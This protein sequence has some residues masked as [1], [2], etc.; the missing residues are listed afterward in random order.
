M[1]RTVRALFLL[2]GL[3]LTQQA[4]AQ[5]VG[6]VNGSFDVTATGTSTY[7]LP[8][9]SVPGSSGLA[10]SLSLSYNSQYIGGPLGAGWSVVGLST[11][12]RG[13]RS[14]RPHGRITGV[15]LDESDLLFL[16]GEELVPIAQAGSGATQRTEYRKRNDD[17]SRIIRTGNAFASA[18]FEVQTK[19]GLRLIFDGDG[20]S[21]IAAG[22]T[23]LLQ[24]VS[25]IED[26]S[27]NFMAFEYF[28]NGY[29]DYNLA[30]VKYTGHRGSGG[31]DRQP[32]AAITFEYEAA[33]RSTTSYVA[34]QPVTSDRRLKAVW[35]G[36]L[37]GPSA[38]SQL[39]KYTF[40]YKDTA[41][42]GRFLLT[43]IHEFGTDGS[44]ISPVRFDYT[45]ASVSWTPAPAQLPVI[46]FATQ[47]AIGLGYRA[48]N[49]TAGDASPDLLFG[50]EVDGKLESFAFTNVAGAWVA[51]DKFKPPFAFA[52]ADGGDLGV[53]AGD[54]NG[55]GRI[56]LIQRTKRA[57]G[58]RAD[59]ALLASDA[60]WQPAEGYKLPFF[61]SEA[62]KRSGSAVL[63]KLS[64]A[65]R[66]DLLYEIGDKR[67]VLVNTGTGWSAA[68]GPSL[69]APLTGSIILDVDCDGRDEFLARVTANGASAWAGW[70]LADGVWEPLGEKYLPP[71][72]AVGIEA[73]LP[74]TLN[75]DNCPDLLLAGAVRLALAGS[76]EGWSQITGMTPDFSILDANGNSLE[77][78]TGDFD[79]NGLTD[80]LIHRRNEAGAVVSSAHLA[81][82]GGGWRADR[83]FVPTL[84]ADLKQRYRAPPIVADVNGDARSDILL[85]GDTRDSFG[86]VLLGGSD[87]LVAAPNYAP[88][89]VF[90]RSDMQDRGIRFVDLNADGLLD[91]IY[92]RDATREGKLEVA[93]GALLN[94]GT[95]WQSEPGLEPPLPF[96]G[97]SITGSPVQFT[98]VNGDGQVDLLYSYN[99][100][101]GE[102]Q[103]KLWLNTRGPDGRRKWI[104]ASGS[105][106]AP[107]ANVVFATEGVGDSG[108]RIADINGDGRADMIAGSIVGK[109]FGDN[110]S[111]QTCGGGESGQLCEWNRELFQSLAYLNSGDGWEFAPAYASPVPFVAFGSPNAPG[112]AD[113]GVL[114][115]D[116]TGDGLADLVASFAH[117][118]DT[119]K[120]LKE[121]WKNTGSGW[122]LEG[123]TI[124][125]RLDEPTDNARSLVQWSDL[126]GDGLV[127]IVLSERRG[128]TNGSE[129]WL[130]TGRGFVPAP[131]FR[132]PL[133]AMADREGDP[134]FRLVDVNGDGLADIIAARMGSNNTPVRRL[135][136]NTG[137]AFSAAPNE[138]LQA[139]PAFI[140][141]D[142][143]DQGVRLF[144]LNA[145][146]L[147]DVLQSYAAGPS[148]EI[149]PASIM[150][151]GGGR[152]DMLAR[153]SNGFG[154]TTVI[155]YQPMG[156]P[157][158]GEDGFPWSRVYEPGAGEVS[159]PLVR[160][161]P[162]TYLVARV[163][164]DDPSSDAVQFSYRYGQLLFD[165]REMKSL[166][167]AWRESLNETSGIIQRSDFSQTSELSGRPLRTASCWLALDRPNDLGGR[168][169]LCDA[170]AG[171]AWSK[172]ISETRFEWIQRKAPVAVTPMEKSEVQRVL[173]A[174]TR[175][176]E[177]ELDGG[178]VAE[179]RTTLTYSEDPVSF[180]AG[181]AN[182]TV[183]TTTRLD[184]TSTIVTNE[185][186]DDT[187]RWFL[188]R[189]T[190]T[191]IDKS[192]PPNAGTAA[193][194][195]RRVIAYAYD[196]VTGLIRSETSDAGHPAAVLK[197]YERDVSGN[198]TRITTSAAGVSSRV[199][200]SDYDLTGRFTV[201]ERIIGSNVRFET[202]I[203]RD[204][205]TGAPLSQTDPNG[206]VA[207]LT[208]DGFGR[209]VEATSPTGIVSRTRYLLVGELEDQQAATGTKAVFATISQ[210]GSLAPVITL[211]DARDRVLRT[212]TQG[213]DRSGRSRPIHTDFEFN[214][215]GQIT[216]ES[217]PYDR[218]KTPQWAQISYDALGRPLVTTTPDGARV[219][220]SYR[221]RPGGGRVLSVRDALGREVS[222]ELDASGLT[223]SSRDAM[224]GRT[225]YQYDASGR[226]VATTGPT[227]IKLR[228]QYDELGRRVLT[229][230]P[231][232]GIWRYRYDPFGQL[233]E[234]VDAKN[235]LTTFE[236]DPIGR[237]VLR[238]SPDRTVQWE[239]DK[240]TGATGKLSRVYE[241]DSYE[242]AL[243]YDALGRAT[244]EL[245]TILGEQYRTRLV[246]D[247]YD[248]IV[249]T[250]YPSIDG[251]QGLTVR[252]H[253]DARGFLYRITNATGTE[254]YWDAV[255]TDVDGRVVEELFGNGIATQRTYDS[256]TGL[257]RR[258]QITPSAGGSSLLDLNLE[259][260][261][262]GNLTRR[263]ETTRN[264]N[265]R[266]VYDE[267][268]RLVRL[269]H[270][271]G[272]NDHYVF[273]K[274]GRL[275]SKPDAGTL[276]YRDPGTGPW[277]PAHAVIRTTIAGVG[278]A[279][280]YDPNGNRVEDGR[281]TY[282]YTSDNRVASVTL[283]A[284]PE[285]GVS[286]EYDPFG[287]RYFEVYTERGKRVETVTIGLF[288][289]VRELATAPGSTLRLNQTRYRYQIAGPSGVFLTLETIVRADAPAAVQRH[290]WYAHKDQLGSVLRITDGKGQL[291]ARFW[292][293]PWGKAA[294]TFLPAGNA[295]TGSWQRTFASQQ[296]FAELG[297]IHMNGRIYDYVTGQFVSADPLGEGVGDP[298][299]LNRYAYASN[300]PLRSADQTGYG[301]FKKIGKAFKK[302]GDGI[303]NGIR[304]IG[305]ETSKWWK[306]NWREVVIVAAAVITVAS[307]GSS[308][309]ATCAIMAGMAAGAVAGGTAAALYGGS[310]EDVITGAATGA[311]IGGVTAGF[312]YGIGEAW[313]AGSAA[314]IGA[315]GVLGG[316]TE[317]ARG[318]EFGRGFFVGSAGALGE[319]YLPE[320][321]EAGSTANVARAAAVGGTLSTISG[322]NFSNGAILAAFAYRFNHAVHQKMG[323]L[324]AFGDY[325]AGGGETHI[326]DISEFEEVSFGD[327]ITSGS[328]DDR[329]LTQVGL[330]LA[331][332]DGDYYIDTEM[333]L[334]RIGGLPSAKSGGIAY[335]TRTMPNKYVLGSVTLHLK[336]SLH[337]YQGQYYFTGTMRVAND[338]YNMNRS[339]HRSAF[340]EAATTFG[341]GMGRITGGRP[342]NVEIRGSR[343]VNA[344]GYIGP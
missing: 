71:A 322:G 26:T 129:T 127:D 185:Y 94:T 212:V 176:R 90:A 103:R 214:R 285:V 341:R 163:L 220:R 14:L 278:T 267:I 87:A 118:W 334:P 112:T 318:G 109:Q 36:L 265:E 96:A 61:L 165:A 92:R 250:T 337:V 275:V 236:Y 2:A 307:F 50:L 34:G 335:A 237:I 107:P 59:S 246:L 257:A 136:L 213:F 70:R 86:T 67:G 171:L 260:D 216:R 339:T 198:V 91:V 47:E 15:E 210:T 342:F 114:V 120:I 169:S 202:R 302:L 167:F 16:D 134:A 138:A 54:I 145:D 168:A 172:P 201:A 24:A 317:V 344:G 148:N 242:K 340:G 255:K 105:P 319:A 232:M 281:R 206:A 245:I 55:D 312:A 117:P 51:E 38:T 329:R 99:R 108:L 128:S 277:A 320:F 192:R 304:N 104:D 323:V 252:N 207:T 292:Y 291:A 288:E 150:L 189:L 130:G 33:P 290:A 266:F 23:V 336:G 131:N 10:P 208:Y 135:W 225:T 324:S 221:S 287:D 283:K 190:R 161:V 239:Y 241:T 111:V 116:V 191:T 217:R 115:A 56:D 330:S 159:Y 244:G 137:N 166:G 209:V 95:G 88:K 69:P 139:I 79:G 3:L 124:P 197:R 41:T 199:N 123:M 17:Q 331:A 256:K 215:L 296:L 62:G 196:P 98:D 321:G 224:N 28:Q 264:I 188:G 43:A 205:K 48:G 122:R 154:L 272:T 253:Y 78:V 106:L 110:R 338:N 84:L 177:W 21:R 32:Y 97:D 316:V 247:D 303:S 76:P 219:T 40:D 273:D 299:G 25:S 157:F 18:R 186:A 9:R 289:R 211:Y 160:P 314:N 57:D 271:N 39:V 158:G 42:A 142:G 262:A 133:D 333:A 4:A 263:R 68:A 233:V 282:S 261:Q 119:S 12:T 126:N 63:A 93:S 251:Q 5:E 182:A 83:A 274:A 231:D 226:M 223:L 203:D 125:L 82:T 52:T 240:G 218:G 248:R 89:V 164:I 325:L 149:A 284:S 46:A 44:E 144:D 229:N 1:I 181:S 74:A 183:T 173:L 180:F 8:I 155:S 53:L 66:A 102:Q 293:D 222:A 29:G 60:G 279:Y 238:Q 230:D 234:Q 151:N 27:G 140:D 49:L 200:E 249:E 184:G 309:V 141:K 121:V 30:A 298:H 152:A 72:A 328:G 187:A 81:Q 73:V 259:Y 45:E 162:S 174:A 235:Q 310:F 313:A 178:L 22:G 64:N 270:S 269:T 146:G 75:S 308:C 35:S 58:G 175:A 254:G 194:T 65:G 258:I 132:I 6:A 280:R 143:R 101:N 227:G 286:F 276:A 315:H 113:L 195:E 300:N 326:Y 100:S 7:S 294:S 31:V 343:A 193:S 295:I 37:E 85:P 156:K 306:N 228:H 305:R 297:L 311:I 11:I 332:G 19:G 80:I 268:N 327:L 243:S 301:L 147:P 153:I 170:E 77:P 13:G 179:E 204:S 20:N